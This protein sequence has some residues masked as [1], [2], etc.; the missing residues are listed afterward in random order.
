MW[1]WNL[2]LGPEGPAPVGTGSQ[3]CQG[4]DVIFGTRLPGLE[5]QLY[6]LVTS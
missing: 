3:A 1:G 2:A 6:H 4:Q 5:S